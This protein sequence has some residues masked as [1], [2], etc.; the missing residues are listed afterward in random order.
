ML[1]ELLSLCSSQSGRPCV[2]VYVCTCVCVYVRMC[3]GL[4][5][6]MR[7]FYCMYCLSK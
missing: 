3:I 4:S 2:R 5:M 6:G 7:V 1:Y